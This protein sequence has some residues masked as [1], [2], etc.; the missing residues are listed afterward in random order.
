MRIIGLDPGLRVTGWGVVDIS[1]NHI[2][3]VANGV[4][5]STGT[6]LPDRLLALFEQLSKVVEN[7]SPDTAAVEKVFVNM[8]STGSLK[9]GHARAM[10]LLVV[11]RAGMQVAEYA[12]NSVKKAVVGAGHADKQQ[13]QHM[14]QMQLGGVKISGSDASDALAVALTHAFLGR[15]SGNL[16]RAV[17]QA[18]Q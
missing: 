13:I 15:Y 6:S 9:L 12:P 8:D 1:G 10:S 3:H 2:S 18:E 5:R 14:V 16:E 4:C 7:F 11:A 17:A